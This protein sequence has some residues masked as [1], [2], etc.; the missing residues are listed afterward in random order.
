MTNYILNIY[1]YIYYK[2][3]KYNVGRKE[4]RFQEK[5]FHLK[6]TQWNRIIE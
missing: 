5:R 3:K 2:K 6:M 4:S 1:K